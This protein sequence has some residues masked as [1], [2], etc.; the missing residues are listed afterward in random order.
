MDSVRKHNPAFGKS[1]A[2]TSAISW[3]NFLRARF[4][5]RVAFVIVVGTHFSPHTTFA[6][7]PL[8]NNP[9]G[10]MAYFMG[11]RNSDIQIALGTNRDQMVLVFALRKDLSEQVRNA[12]AARRNAGF[13]YDATLAK[14]EKSGDG[15]L[16]AILKP[17]QFRRLTGIHFQQLGAR[18]FARKDVRTLLKLTSKQNAAIDG[19]LKSD[20]D[21]K[22]TEITDELSD[23]QAAT[24][25]K[26]LGPKVNLPKPVKRSRSGSSRR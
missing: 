23:D 9:G 19:I 12:Q 8:R 26:T 11:E 25:K 17:E 16:K 21:E 18:A 15:I 4:C 5:W 13:D 10:L 14:I 6:Q 1:P 22:L 2:N 20:S 3:R 7:R 24:W